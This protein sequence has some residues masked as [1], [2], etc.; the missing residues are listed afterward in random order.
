MIRYLYHSATAATLNLEPRKT[1][2]ASVM[3]P[4]F[5]ENSSHGEKRSQEQFSKIIWV[6]LREFGVSVQDPPA[7]KINAFGILGFIVAKLECHTGTIHFQTAMPFPR[8][9][10]GCG[11]PVVKNVIVQ[12]PWQLNAHH[13]HRGPHLDPPQ[14]LS[15]REA[16]ESE[17]NHEWKIVA[18]VISANPLKN[19]RI[20][21]FE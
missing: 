12:P 15:S 8:L 13:T 11:S 7:V 14:D 21:K 16:L 6:P 17:S 1:E 9:E 18:A 4:E 3:G 20:G 5:N 19:R 10:K 2:W